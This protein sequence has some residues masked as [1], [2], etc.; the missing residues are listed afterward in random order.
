MK[1]DADILII[2]AGPAGAVA[3]ALLVRQGWSVMVLERAH[4]PRFVIGESL[5]PAMMSVL[6]AAG[7][8]EAVR[9]AG[10]QRK[11]GAFFTWREHAAR[12]DFRDNASGENGDI[13]EVKRAEFDQLLID[14]AVA[15]GAEVRYGQ[16][17]TGFV[18]DENGAELSVRDEASGEAYTLNA[19][20][21]LDASGYGRV[22][23]RL[24]DL[25]TPSS[26]P[27]RKVFATHLRDHIS[28]TDYDRNMITI[29]TLANARDRWMWLIP[30]SDGT[31]SIGVIG[32][33]EQ[34]DDSDPLAQLQGAVAEVPFLQRILSDAEWDIGVPVR[35]FSHFSASVKT[36]YGK[37]FA[38]LGNAAEF[39]D[40][41][42]SSGV[43]IALHSAQLAA[44]LVD[45]ELRGEPTDWQ[46]EFAD[47]VLY[48]VRVFQTYVQAWYDGRFQDVI[49]SS[50]DNPSMKR[51][52][53]AILAGYAWDRRN[54]FVCE[55]ER[56]L[57]MISDVVREYGFAPNA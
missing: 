17:V 42:F 14:G 33:P 11:Y 23:A 29:A 21:V 10:F 45:R 6:D 4:F 56:R 49:Y 25:E 26:L 41:V 12:I 36:L 20:F 57:N 1:H 39:L 34:M 16:S 50:H 52:I 43:T 38:L 35:A 27:P 7:L 18:E 24:L 55:P 2:G 9:R 46:R 40:P 32:R 44:N 51:Y 19:R 15:Q 13:F 53:S 47:E 28:A 54:P 8:G 3:A 30:F 5:L 31:A 48:G 37:R 22:L